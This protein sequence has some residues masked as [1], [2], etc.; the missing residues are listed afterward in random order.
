[1]MARMVAPLRITGVAAAAAAL[2]LGSGI[3][4]QA[5]TTHGTPVFRATPRSAPAAT[6]SDGSCNAPGTSS[7]AA[8]IGADK[9]V[10]VGAKPSSMTAVWLP[11][12]NATHCVARRTVSGA[13]LAVKVASALDHTKAMPD[14]PLPCPFADG[15]SV[16]LYFDYPNGSSEYADVSLGGCRPI[17]APGRAARWGNTTQ[18]E[19]TLL[20][21]A[22][23]A[24]RTYLGGRAAT[25]KLQAASAAHHG[26]PVNEVAPVNAPLTKEHKGVCTVESPAPG[27]NVESTKGRVWVYRNARRVVTVWIPSEDTGHCVAVRKMDTASFADPI[28]AAIEH[29]PAMPRGIFCP[30]DDGSSVR[31]YLGFNSGVQQY[32][33]VE[34]SGCHT[35]SA[36][37]RSPR[38]MTP[39]LTRAL[40]R[41][42]PPG[43]D[44]YLDA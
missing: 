12:L 6:E 35:V 40:R 19:N 43:W 38:E 44:H 15:T 13:A 10:W 11:G 26:T 9:L 21:A 16:Q 22:P 1:M 17:S 42:V 33:N 24:W 27:G 30:R 28:A 36:P 2:L 18:F 25:S 20:P 3:S 14:K 34:L 41:I 29:A 31:I 7:S 32:V 39:A 8:A 23:S 5:A 37:G 4:A